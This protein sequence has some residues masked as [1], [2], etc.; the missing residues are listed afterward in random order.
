MTPGDESAFPELDHDAI[1][2]TIATGGLTKRELFA[3]MAM[4]NLQNVLLRKGNAELLNRLKI[5]LGEGD[6]HIIIARL[7][8][9]QADH[10][11]A[12]LA[13]PREGG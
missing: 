12:E 8:A 10:L 6:E 13:K 3:A 7:A 5:D 4:M 9:I 1:G 11:L 2:S